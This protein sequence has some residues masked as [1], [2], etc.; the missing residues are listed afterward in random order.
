M[1]G[2]PQSRRFGGTDQKPAKPK[3]SG[4]SPALFYGIFAV[5]FG[6][7]VMTLVGF[8]MSPDI[9]RLFNGQENE[10]VSAYEERIDQL[11]IEVDRL[12]SRSYAQAGDVNLQL[13]ELAQQQEILTEQHQYVKALAEKAAELG[14]Q[15]AALPASDDGTDNIGAEPAPAYV[16]TGNKDIDTSEIQV[17]QM[18]GE[19]RMA[20][21]AISQAATSSTDEILSELG[22]IGINPTMPS[23]N[24]AMGGPYLPANDGPEASSMVDDANG[25]ADAL[26]RY[27]LAR[28]AIDAAPV[29]TPMEGNVRMSSTFGNRTDPFTGRL[30]FHSGMDFGAPTGT[31]VLSAGAGEV[32]FVGQKSGYGN[33]VE[34]THANGLLTRYGHLS[35]FLV[36]EG[37]PV[38]TGT[39]IAKVGTTGRSTGPHLHFEVRKADQPINPAKYLNAGKKLQRFLQAA[40]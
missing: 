27:K 24:E 8:L 19:T 3:G 35:A 36:K 10:I 26:T 20:L 13:Q 28:N 23:G 9:S 30:A 1:R 22:R 5:L 4:I 12:H 7:N 25:V 15:P 18:M 37:Q 31:T 6:T 39:P 38:N 34:V 40:V 11:R 21:A 33:V 2:K 16:P 29:H 14:I 17:R 32:S